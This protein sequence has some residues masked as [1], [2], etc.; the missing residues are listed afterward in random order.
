M[1]EFLVNSSVCVKKLHLKFFHQARKRPDSLR[2]AFGCVCGELI[3]EK[4]YTASI[5][6]AGSGE[7]VS[8]F[9]V[10]HGAVAPIY[11]LTDRGRPSTTP[12]DIQQHSSSSCC[13]V[14]SQ[15]PLPQQQQQ[16]RGQGQRWRWRWPR[17]MSCGTA[18]RLGLTRSPHQQNSQFYIFFLETN[19]GDTNRSRSTIAIAAQQQQRQ[20]QQQ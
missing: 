9:E 3:A 16:R 8:N 18:A 4:A 19:A 2:N 10:R 17:Q 1:A 20:Q 12:S 11:R 13:A 6:Q 7:T 14:A 15:Q 5:A